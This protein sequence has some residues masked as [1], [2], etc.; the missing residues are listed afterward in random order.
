VAEALHRVVR[1]TR[2]GCARGTPENMRVSKA[3][4]NRLHRAFPKSQWAKD[5]PYWFE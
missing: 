4:F 2:Y 5:T 3:A 1:V